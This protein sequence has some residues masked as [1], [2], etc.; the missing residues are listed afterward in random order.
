MNQKMEKIRKYIRKVLLESV[1]PIP[2]LKTKL[3]SDQAYEILDKY[4]GGTWTAGGCA[5]LA[6]AL[7]KIHNAPIWVIFNQKKNVVEHFVVKIGRHKFMDYDGIHNN[8]IKD[9]RENEMV[10]DDPLV[11]MPYTKRMP[12][13]D[14]I[15]NNQAAKEV[16]IM[17]EKIMYLETKHRTKL[18]IKNG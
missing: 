3:D 10:Y 17:I 13:S 18:I 9:F 8:I 7:A 4:A 12:I 16:M 2:E 6:T 15:M 5:I 11:L 1:T 14:I